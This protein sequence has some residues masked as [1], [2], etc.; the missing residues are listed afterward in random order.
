[1]ANV[2]EELEKLSVAERLQLVEDLW[3]SIARS[4]TEVPIPQWQKDELARRKEIFLRN[5]DSVLTWDQAKR[6]IL[7]SQ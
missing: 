6:D 5:P 3:D 4:N 7:Q 2:L 1:M